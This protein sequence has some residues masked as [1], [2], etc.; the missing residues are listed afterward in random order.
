MKM[1]AR[2]VII[3]NLSDFDQDILNDLMVLFGEKTASKAVIK[4]LREF[5]RLKERETI[6]ESITETLQSE[7]NELRE[8]VENIRKSLKD[9]EEE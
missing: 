3:R 5:K 9:L 6:L 2:N 8:K 1:G 4:M 7:N